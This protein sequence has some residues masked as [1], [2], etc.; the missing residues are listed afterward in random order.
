MDAYVRFALVSDVH[1]GPPAYF[2]GRLSKLSHAAPNLLRG[3][4]E[5][6]SRTEH[7]EL[8]VNLGDVVEDENHDADQ[9]RYAEFV[10]LLGQAGSPVV[11]VVG[12]HDSI[13]LSDDE[14]SSLWK[15]SEP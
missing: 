15:H 6:L 14:I 9:G 5:K 12:N 2:A 4:V 11:H 13:N 3:V 10:A 7:P 1:F 8:V